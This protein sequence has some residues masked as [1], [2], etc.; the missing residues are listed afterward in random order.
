MIIKNLTEEQIVDIIDG[1]V[2]AMGYVGTDRICDR[3]RDRDFD[4]NRDSDRGT[5]KNFVTECED[6]S[7]IGDVIDIYSNNV[8]FDE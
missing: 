6:L 3:N 8:V 1:N 5:D 2:L 7:T 4:R